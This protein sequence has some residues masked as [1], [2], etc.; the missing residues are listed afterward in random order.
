[1]GILT[2]GRE[3]GNMKFTFAPES[4][5]LDGYTIK[6]A[7]YRGGFGEVYYALTDAGRE[8]ALKLLQNN[9]EIELRGVQQCLNLSHPNLVTIFDVKQ[10]RDGDHWIIM[11]YVAGETLDMAIHRHPNG[12]P[13]EE[14]R[15]W[16]RGIADGVGFLH[17]QGIVHRDLKPGNVF[18]EA[19]VVKIGDVGLSKFITPSRRSAQT[20]SVGTVYYMAPE[21]A[22]GRYGMEVDVYALGIMLYEMIAGRV[23]FEGESTGEILMKHLSEKP[24]LTRLPERL[25]P[26][27]DIALQKDPKE[28]FSSV[29]ELHEAFES[30]VI[31]TYT[32]PQPK[33]ASEPIQ[34][35]RQVD[36]IPGRQRVSDLDETVH[37]PIGSDQQESIWWPSK[38]AFMGMLAIGTAVMVWGEAHRVEG[39]HI[40]M[41]C[42]AL[43]YIVYTLLR[44]SQTNRARSI[45]SHIDKSSLPI[46]YGGNHWW[47]LGLFGWLGV[48]AVLANADLGAVGKSVVPFGAAW[49]II[50]YI[51]HTMV[52]RLIKG[53]WRDLNAA[54]DSATMSP[55]PPVSPAPSR[56][57][58]ATP[59]KV[60]RVAQPVRHARRG[61]P[62][63]RHYYRNKPVTPAFARP[64]SMRTRMTQFSTSAALVIPIIALLTGGVF[65]VA[66]DFFASGFGN[67][68]AWENIGLFGATAAIGAWL[69][70]GLSKWNEGRRV[71]GSTRRLLQFLAGGVVGLAAFA[72]SEGLLIGTEIPSDVYDGTLWS[73]S[74][75]PMFVSVGGRPLFEE[76]GR[77]TLLGFVGFF[78]ALFGLRRWWWHTDSFRQKRFRIGSVLLTVCMAWLVS[79]IWAFPPIWAMTWAAVISSGVQLASVWTPPEERF[80]TRE[81]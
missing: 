46:G 80:V 18:S 24:D 3:S 52:P 5:P 42:S 79:S 61:R 33:A 4:R 63:G 21:V 55:P 77:P 70:M 25:R 29:R 56:P 7:I 17:D 32:A 65:L 10:D 81:V 54:N 75:D 71:D 44:R 67:G 49:W 74:S 60:V 59:S 30:A 6:R 36:P 68:P 9:S 23:P 19:N 45:L 31:G 53:S 13:M 41:C 22:K 47:I 50:G 73:Q 78:A 72:V 39:V 57:P 43:T 51:A 40:A 37:F 76:G 1:M 14:V 28:R 2:S 11:E 20:Q 16:L 48:N 62:V 38:R 27:L 15:K 12:M 34:P 66:P 69:L 64:V 35:G 8:V 58:H 26:V